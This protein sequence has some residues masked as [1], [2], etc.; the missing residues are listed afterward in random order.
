[1]SKF[2]YQVAVNAPL[3]DAL[4]YLP[5][6]DGSPLVRGQSVQVPLGK[7][8]A[9]GV[10]LGTTEIKSEYTLK[11]I[12]E[13]VHERPTVSDKFLQWIEWIAKYYLYPVGQI[14]ET[15]FPPLSRKGERASKRAPVVPDLATPEPLNLTA[16]QAQVVEAMS[17]LSQ[18]QVHLLHGVT[19]SGKTEVYLRLLEKLL[20]DG[21]QG[22]VLVPEIS[23]TPQL[24]D[25]FSARFPGQVAVIHSHLTEREKTNQWWN[26]V[27]GKTNI[28]IGAR[29][30][31][32]CPMPRLGL[33]VVDEE[34]EPSYKQDEKLKYHARD[35]AVMLGKFLNCPVLLGSAT[36]SLE[37]WNNAIE[38]RYKMHTMSLRV[39]ERSLPEV[40]VVDLREVARKRRDTPSDLPFWLSEHLFEEMKTTLNR[41]EQSALFLNRRGIAQL[42]QCPACGYVAECPNC[43][44]SLTLHANNHLVCHYCD[45]TDRLR[46]ACSQCPDGE[47]RAVGLGT[48]RVESDVR[49]LFPDAVVARADRDEIQNRE[50]LEELIRDMETGKTQILVG[51]QM[52]AK[53]LD[54]PKLTLV[55]LVLADIGFHWPDFRASE[56]SFQ[57]MT[58]VSGRSGRHSE[59]PGRVVI[60][61]YNPEHPSILSTLRANFAEFSTAELIERKLL[62]YPPFHRV[63]MFRIQGQD[64][65]KTKTAAK[66]LAERARHLQTRSQNYTQVSI[67]GPAPAPLAKLRGRY[68]FQLMVKGPTAPIL[69]GFLSQ[70]LSDEKWLPT[71]TKVQ[72]DVDP[73]QML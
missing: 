4:T 13:A 62:N 39:M 54:F 5:P 45:F 1:M 8:Q 48:E 56:R 53:G 57:L 43:S 68:R 3:K 10:I 30:A 37:S 28:L 64:L 24:I 67:L 63:A 44:V 41:G 11:P 20:A 17:D 33:I 27:E 7:R 58:Q 22:L 15:A 19:G 69:N 2:L 38:G 18:F 49:D 12:T 46:T 66:K 21:K 61:T 16:E 50:Q 14:A 35:C 60:Q 73:C 23:L 9:T 51:T 25:R 29:S 42:A 71:G 72:V 52:I 70:I 31:L 40:A 32:F 65:I 47:V 55:G 59:I 26:M 34:H 6:L 36:P